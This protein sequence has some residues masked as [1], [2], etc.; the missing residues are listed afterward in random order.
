MLFRSIRLANYDPLTQLHNR[1][2]FHDCLQRA[3]SRSAR[4]ASS[5]AVL[6]LDLDHF[7]HV[8]DTLGHDVGDAL[9][10]E[11]SQRL[12]GLLRQSDT[13]ARLGGDE[14]VLILEDTAL[15]TSDE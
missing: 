8:N 12:K 2:A 10:V 9:L 7:K 15:S 13:G 5:V 11:V 14:F 4:F 3:I 1:A 6:M